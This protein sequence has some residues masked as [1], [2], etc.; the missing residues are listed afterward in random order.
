M[1][2]NKKKKSSPKN[3]IIGIT[4]IGLSAF[5]INMYYQ[6]TLKY[7]S[8]DNAYVN[9]NLVNVAPKVGGFIKNI[10]VTKN[11]HVKA[12]DILF[13]IDPLDY[14]LETTSREQNVLVSE[15][16][17]QA[18]KQNVDIAKTNIAKAQS[19]Y[20]FNKKL[21]V[22]YTNLYN[23]KAGTLQDM[24]KYNNQL[25]QSLE[26]LNA[27]KLS[28]DQTKTQYETYL[29][30]IKLNKTALDSA[31]LKTSYTIVK[32]SVDGYIANLNLADGQLVQAGQNVF[33]LVDDNAWWID[34][35]FKETQ[36][37]R[38]KPG[39]K[40]KVVLDM[41]P[42]HTYIG[43]ITSISRNSGS[44]FSILPAQNATGNWVKVTQRFPVEIKVQD[45]PKYPLRVGSSAYVTVDTTTAGKK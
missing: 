1:Q 37:E 41:Y 31:K 18:M 38:L 10:N 5:G 36:M 27:A 13:E 17:A 21:A 44:T 6:H 9:A 8:T 14:D 34:A 19:D 35:N 15:Q 25:T 29:S 22:R 30:Q 20:D 7:P 42:D 2:E 28:Y 4:I 12:G 32:S 43:E 45:D 33:G 26:Q 3:I 40:V 39:Q 23:E 11:Q 24:Q 16:Q